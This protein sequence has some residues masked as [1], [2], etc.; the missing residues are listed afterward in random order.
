MPI[1]EPEVERTLLHLEFRIRQYAGAVRLTG[2]RFLLS[3]DL[4]V[5]RILPSGAQVD[6]EPWKTVR[7]RPALA[8][9]G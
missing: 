3:P 1:D 2:N 5:Y 6:L 4:S 8:P 7:V 9:V